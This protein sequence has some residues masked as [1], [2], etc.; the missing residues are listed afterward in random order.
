M[1]G[2]GSMTG[3]SILRSCDSLKNA[4]KLFEICGVLISNFEL[5]SEIVL[6]F[7]ADS[8]RLWNILNVILDDTDFQSRRWLFCAC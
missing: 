2:R 3:L 5:I 1:D 6:Y 8:L 7:E 4:D